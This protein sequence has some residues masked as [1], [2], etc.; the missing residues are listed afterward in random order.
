MN[1]LAAPA[2]ADKIAATY[3]RHSNDRKGRECEPDFSLERK[4]TRA[5][6]EM[7]EARWNQLQAE[8]SNRP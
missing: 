2:F 3:A 7:G 1:A 5:R 8:W 6:L 4:V